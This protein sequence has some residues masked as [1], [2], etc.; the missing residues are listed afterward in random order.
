MLNRCIF[1]KREKEREKEW[2]VK[3]NQHLLGIAI[4]LIA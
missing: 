3:K 1:E 2:E 4:L